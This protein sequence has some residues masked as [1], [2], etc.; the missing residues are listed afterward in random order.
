MRVGNPNSDTPIRVGVSLCLVLASF[1][2]CTRTDKASAA[3]SSTS[4]L[5]RAGKPTP[6]IQALAS[7]QATV[8]GGEP[9]HA[10]QAPGC[11]VPSP[12]EPPPPAAPAANCPQ[13]PGGAPELRNGTVTFGQAPG[14]PRIQVELA[15]TDESRM[16]G[17]MYRTRME[18]DHGMLFSWHRESIRSFWMKNT[19]LPL[20]MLFI[21][22]SGTIVGILENVP[23]LNQASRGVRCPAAHVLEVNAGYTRENGVFAGQKIQIE[24]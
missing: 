24:R 13:D 23:T 6:A 14:T 4:S 3:G 8:T 17:L 5:E 16:R 2:A 18:R 22:A 11:L 15:D 7:T 10:A 12:K 20:D 1:L 21:D 19:C 9:P